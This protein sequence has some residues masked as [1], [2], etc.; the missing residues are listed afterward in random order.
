MATQVCVSG[1]GGVH[2]GT[3]G[4]LINVH[5]GTVGPLINVHI[6]TVGPG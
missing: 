1:G 5:I 2:I 6:G 3:V 4:P